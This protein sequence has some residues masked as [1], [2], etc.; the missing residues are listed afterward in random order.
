[1]ENVARRYTP[2]TPGG[3]LELSGD[4]SK[5][6]LEK[7]DSYGFTMIHLS[8]MVFQ[9]GEVLSIHVWDVWVNPSMMHKTLSQHSGQVGLKGGTW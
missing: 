3:V 7:I 5:G 8:L 9:V 6:S 4:P 2:G 1:M